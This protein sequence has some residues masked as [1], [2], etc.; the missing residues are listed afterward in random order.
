MSTA[1]MRQRMLDLGGEAMDKIRRRDA[2]REVIQS[3]YRT[4]LWSPF[5]LQPPL[6]GCGPFT[7]VNTNPYWP[8]AYSEAMRWEFEVGRWQDAWM[9]AWRREADYD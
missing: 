8:A 6:A 2:A 3:A 7:P 1:D 4:H 9:K 5:H